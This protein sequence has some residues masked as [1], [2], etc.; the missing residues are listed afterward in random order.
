M[1]AGERARWLRG[2]P[3]LLALFVLLFISSSVAS[4]GLGGV[5]WPSTDAFEYA[6]IATWLAR[7][8]GPLVRIGPAFFPSRFLPTASLLLLPQALLGGADPR[9]YQWAVFAAGCLA[10]AGFWRLGLALGL[11]HR[12]ALTA[13]AALALSP[14]FACYARWVMSDVPSLLCLI[15]LLLV[16]LRAARAGGAGWGAP[17]AV[18]LLCG[19][20]MSFRMVNATWPLALG[21]LWLL[22]ERGA[23]LRRPLRWLPFA[24]GVALP[25]AGIFAYQ[26]AF[27]GG[28]L[29]T[30]YGYW[31]PPYFERFLDP[32]YAF[33]PA[34]RSTT[35]AA[36]VGTRPG[37]SNLGFYLGELAGLHS[38]RFPLPAGFRS[39]VHTLPAAVLGALGLLLAARRREAGRQLRT[40]LGALLFGLLVQLALLCIIKYPDWRFVLP[41]ALLSSL[42]IGVLVD[43][44]GRRP[45]GWLA[46]LLLLPIAVAFFVM[47]LTP[48]DKRL[49]VYRSLVLKEWQRLES[50]PPGP[51]VEQTSIPLS[52]AA[53]A[54]PADVVLVP[55][56]ARFPIGDWHLDLVRRFGIEPLRID[57]GRE[58]LWRGLLRGTVDAPPR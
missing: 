27:F 26:W 31:Y 6:S 49:L 15:A 29:S 4:R 50:V 58:E 33:G 44:L 39:D 56:G 47:P 51:R 34:G 23:L 8:E 21:A 38:E 35:T 24:A 55:S 20:L 57:A 19:V 25:V 18:G 9:S 30:G 2:S 36:W 17:L 14:S 1:S 22:A 40:F 11:S 16:A 43:A 48:L 46:P 52:L 7:G 10:L 5:L 28:P 32:A 3:G 42:G 45:G 12:A 53:L 13:G 54:A 37:D 41:W